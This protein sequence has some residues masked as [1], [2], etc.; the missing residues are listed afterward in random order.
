MNHEPILEALAA[1]PGMRSVDLADKLDR[2]TVEVEGA[3]LALMKIGHVASS[4]STA[5]NG[6]LTLVYNLTDA[7]LASDEAASL[8]A[9]AL[10]AGFRVPGW[11]TMTK[12]D[13]AIAFVRARGT[14]TNAELHIVLGLAPDEYASA[15]L[16]A[17][18]RTNRLIRDGKNWKLGAG[19]GAQEAPAP[20]SPATDASAIAEQRATVIEQMKKSAR[21]LSAATAETAAA[22][23]VEEAAQYATTG[24]WSPPPTE[25]TVPAPVVV[26]ARADARAAVFGNQLTQGL[27]SDPV[28]PPAPDV[29]TDVTTRYGIWSDGTFEVQRNGRTALVLT[30]AELGDMLG[31]IAGARGAE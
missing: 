9:K 5:A 8:R 4:E 16:S 26:G 24:K 13:R 3:L 2:D 27:A 22:A 21:E 23:V 11:E 17:A 1:K 10:V 28:E 18:T 31:F 29:E 12:I 7:F 19:P 20:S 25:A 15:S 14:A 30:D 6:M